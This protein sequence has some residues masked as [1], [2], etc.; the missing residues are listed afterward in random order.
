MMFKQNITVLA[1]APTGFGYDGNVGNV[2]W[3]WTLGHTYREEAHLSGGNTNG[4]QVTYSVSPA[5]PKGV[6]LNA[7][8][9]SIYGTPTI[10]AVANTSYT[11]TAT[12]SG[13]SDS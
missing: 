3:T 13:G 2:G 12:N 5:L 1:Q 10:L 4:A 8:T 11:V 9:G 6:A 7:T